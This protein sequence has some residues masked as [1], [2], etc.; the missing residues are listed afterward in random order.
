MHRE[1]FLLIENSNPQ[2]KPSL[3][4]DHY[5]LPL[6]LITVSKLFPEPENCSP[7][8]RMSEALST[9]EKS[10]Q[11]VLIDLM[12]EKSMSMSEGIQASSTKT[13]QASPSTAHGA[14]P[15]C[16]RRTKHKDDLAN[17][18]LIS[19]ILPAYLPPLSTVIN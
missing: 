9:A 19:I 3:Y 16:E 6:Y 11:E 5:A 13:V 10:A 2:T 18:K 17:A 15:S 7:R 14:G 8:V 12:T 4:S 1:H